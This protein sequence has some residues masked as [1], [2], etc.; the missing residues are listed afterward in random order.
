MKRFLILAALIGGALL[1]SLP[2]DAMA[3]GPNW[4]ARRGYY[5]G[6]YGNPC[7]RPYPYRPAYC[8]RAPVYS[9]SFGAAY[10]RPYY[11][12]GYYRGGYSYPAA[13]WDRDRDRGRYRRR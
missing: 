6:Y 11:D 5:G 7:Y 13:R 2:T 3:H 12:Y 10:P 1:A 8:Y 9:Y 4:Y